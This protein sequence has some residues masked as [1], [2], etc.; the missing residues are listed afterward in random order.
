MKFQS[1]DAS[2]LTADEWEK[3]A[4]IQ[5]AVPGATLQLREHRAQTKLCDRTNDEHHA[6]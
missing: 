1:V 3:F 5:A 6:R 4:E 2:E